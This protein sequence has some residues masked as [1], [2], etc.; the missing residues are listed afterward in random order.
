M[1]LLL[2]KDESLADLEQETN[3]ELL[4]Y[5]RWN[6]QNLKVTLLVYKHVHLQDGG[7]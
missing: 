5:C 3:L 1:I 2:L 4:K 6:S 7:T